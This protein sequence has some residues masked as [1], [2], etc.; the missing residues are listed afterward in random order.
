ME[1]ILGEKNEKIKWAFF[2][3]KKDDLPSRKSVKLFPDHFGRVRIVSDQ[4]RVV[5]TD[6]LLTNQKKT[7]IMKT[8]DCV[9]V[10]VWWP[11]E[12]WVG[13]LHFGYRGLLFGLAKNFLR[14]VNKNN[15]EIS[16]ANFLLGPAICFDCYTH[17][18]LLRKFKWG[19]LKFKNSKFAKVS[20]KT[21]KFDLVSASIEELLKIGVRRKNIKS[22]KG[23]CTNC[24]LGL[25]RHYKIKD[26]TLLTTL[27]RI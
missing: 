6:G 19:V 10:I 7:L 13:I 22:V 9:P 11:N 17:K 27:D 16:E 25:S 1:Q 26:V 24:R 4:D 8:A 12:N 14:A 23:Y 2:R 20:N 18:T 3:C 21:Y 5:K 15:L